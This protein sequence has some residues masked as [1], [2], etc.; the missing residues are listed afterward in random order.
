MR[1]K[2]D[3]DVAYQSTVRFYLHPYIRNEIKNWTSGAV[4]GRIDIQEAGILRGC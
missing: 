4:I 1:G 3:G 2:I